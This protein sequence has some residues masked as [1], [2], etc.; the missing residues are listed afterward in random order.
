MMVWR[1]WVSRCREEPSAALMALYFDLFLLHQFVLT[2]TE[3][4][5]LQHH[6]ERL[7]MTRDKDGSEGLFFTI[8]KTKQDYVY[9]DDFS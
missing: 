5:Y 8:G 3:D 9:C 1:E 7:R 4:Y 2:T 6:D